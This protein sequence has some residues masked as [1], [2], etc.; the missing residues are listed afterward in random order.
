MTRPAITITILKPIQPKGWTSYF[1]PESARFEYDSYKP[2]AKK[3]HLIIF[4]RGPNYGAVG[5]MCA[6]FRHPEL[7]ELEREGYV[8]IH[9]MPRRDKQE[10]N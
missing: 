5:D 1:Y 2:T 6:G 9:G 10:G 4:Q 7:L 8:R 3:V